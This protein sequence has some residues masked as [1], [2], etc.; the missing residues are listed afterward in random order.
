[1]WQLEIVNAVKLYSQEKIKEIGKN[2]YARIYLIYVHQ[3]RPTP[4]FKIIKQFSNLQLSTA[5]NWQFACSYSLI[6]LQL[7]LNTDQER[8]TED[9]MRLKLQGGSSEEDFSRGS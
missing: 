7:L 8:Q 5:S 3:T 2:I 1:M 9:K 4:V 6:F